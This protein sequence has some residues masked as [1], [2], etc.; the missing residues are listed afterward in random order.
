[1]KQIKLFLILSLIVISAVKAQ[2]LKE[3]PTPLSMMT[4]SVMEDMYLAME[5]EPKTMMALMLQ[6]P[7]AKAEEL[8]FNSLN[9]IRTMIKDSTGID[10]Q[11]ADALEG[12]VK[13]SR[14]GLPLVSLK[15]AAK[16][17][18]FQQ[19]VKIDIAVSPF[20]GTTTQ[21]TNSTDSPLGVEVG[22]SNYSANWRPEVFVLMKFANAK[23]KGVRTIRGI[24]RHD[25]KVKVTSQDLVVAGWHIPMN[26]E[27][28]VIPYYYFLEKA[29]QDL[30]SKI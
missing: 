1:M 8:M 13:Y 3:V 20:S 12:K 10:I 29:V 23:G 25:E 11:P 14:L 19:Y 5:L 7:N 16:K 21:N 26:Q 27:A 15:K 9:L 30:I 6:Q 2:D 18:D 22:S 4:L 24:Y 17:T 28:E